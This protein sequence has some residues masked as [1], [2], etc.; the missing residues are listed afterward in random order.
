MEIA[1]I[2]VAQSTC[3]SSLFSDLYDKTKTYIQYK[4]NKNTYK[5]IVIVLAT[6]TSLFA[7]NKNV[8]LQIP[9]SFSQLP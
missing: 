8:Q 4:A 7:M 6:F 9:K 1:L 2:Y 5:L 3:I